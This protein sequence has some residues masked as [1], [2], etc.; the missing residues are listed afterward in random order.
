MALVSYSSS[1]M[2]TW[3][4]H[5]IILGSITHTRL[6]T[7]LLGSYTTSYMA[8]W[9]KHDFIHGSRLI[10]GFTLGSLVHT[11]LH[12]WLLT[13][14]KPSYMAPCHIH[15]FIHGSLAHTRPHTGSMA[16]TRLHTRLYLL[17]TT[18]CMLNWLI[19][20][21][22]LH[23]RKS[24]KIKSITFSSFRILYSTSCCAVSSPYLLKLKYT[25][26]ISFMWVIVRMKAYFMKNGQNKDDA[27]LFPL[28]SNC[29]RKVILQNIILVKE[30]VFCLP[31]YNFV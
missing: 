24:I 28:S 29:L 19:S 16:R 10:H 12:T 2:A 7:W 30:T 15:V 5:D 22:I 1:Y 20:V 23:Q 13:S 26:S 14:Y 9:F 3:L 17:Y 21:D 31:S 11:R 25:I 6:H 4:I 8:P 27:T 18:S